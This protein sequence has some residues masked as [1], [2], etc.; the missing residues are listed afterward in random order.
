MN[1]DIFDAIENRNY[2]YLTGKSQNHSAKAGQNQKAVREDIIPNGFAF[3]HL[4]PLK[5]VKVY[6]GYAPSCAYSGMAFI[7]PF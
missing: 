1:P 2:L 6:F 3:M 4:L 5:C 7:R